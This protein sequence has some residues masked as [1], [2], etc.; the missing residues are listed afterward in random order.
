M[1]AA[2]GITIGKTWYDRLLYVTSCARPACSKCYPNAWSTHALYMY[3]K[4]TK[5]I[6]S[7]VFVQKII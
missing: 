2:I 6:Y 1:F 5:N 4:T 3:D 7:T